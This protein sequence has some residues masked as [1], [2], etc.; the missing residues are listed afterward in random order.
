MG[1]VR[2]GP[3]AQLGGGEGGGGGGGGWF[4]VLISPVPFPRSL[5]ANDDACTDY[6]AKYLK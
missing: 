6:G 3:S 5:S 4:N 1:F 2:M